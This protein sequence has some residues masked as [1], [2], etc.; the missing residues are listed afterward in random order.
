MRTIVVSMASGVTLSNVI[1]LGEVYKEVHI[2]IPSMPSGTDIYI[3]GS[4]CGTIYRR[5]YEKVLLGALPNSA[6]IVWTPQY[7]ASSI[8]NCIVDLHHP[9]PWMKIEFSTA[10]TA[11][12]PTF[13]IICSDIIT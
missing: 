4:C 9:F 8:S 1:Q 5:V 6:N 13:S 11:T 3:Q 12:A 10:M 7:V 2:S